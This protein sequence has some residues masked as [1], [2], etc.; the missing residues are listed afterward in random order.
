MVSIV[1]LLVIVF[2]PTWML[3]TP[4]HTHD[5]HTTPTPTPT[6][7]TTRTHIHT[8]IQ[9]KKRYNP[10]DSKAPPV[11]KFEYSPRLA[12]YHRQSDVELLQVLTIYV[13]V[14]IIYSRTWTHHAT[15]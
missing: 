3:N 14:Y 6:T 15:D 1:V 10:I 11:T 13:H 12:S 7:T 2:K 9:L 8:H 4:P 5:T